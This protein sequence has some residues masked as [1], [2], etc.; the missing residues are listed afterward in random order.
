MMR[1][2]GFG[3]L[4]VAEGERAR[5][6]GVSETFELWRGF[7][8]RFGYTMRRQGADAFLCQMSNGINGLG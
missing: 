6:G 3:A 5:G 2:G 1:G 4:D 8:L 7:H